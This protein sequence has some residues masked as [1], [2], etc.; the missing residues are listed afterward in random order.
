MLATRDPDGGA[1]LSAVWF[2][3][4]G[5]DVLVATGGR[6]RKARNAAVRPRASLLL[7]GRE[8]A[9]LYGAAAS[10]SIRIVRGAE[11]RRLNGRVWAKYLTP[12]GIEHPRLGRAIAEHD[13]VTLRFTP[14]RWRVWS[15]DDDFGG[16]FELPG[17]VLPLGAAGGR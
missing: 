2:L 6:T 16:V 1:Y 7:H 10:G 17:L 12:A 13:D 15:T 8:E 9:P 3:R 11:A 5:D 4:D 14:E